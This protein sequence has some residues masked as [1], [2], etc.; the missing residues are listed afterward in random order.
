MVTFLTNEDKVELQEQIDNIKSNS[1]S[2]DITLDVP[3][4]TDYIQGQEAYLYPSMMVRTTDSDWYKKYDFYQHGQYTI[5]N[6]PMGILQLN[7]QIID[8]NT[9]TILENPRNVFTLEDRRDDSNKIQS[10]SAV[11]VGA[12]A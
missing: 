10:T 3:A 12:R 6:R 1:D 7:K 2:V 5:T 11:Y 4:I 9:S 8:V